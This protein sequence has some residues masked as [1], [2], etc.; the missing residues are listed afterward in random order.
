MSNTPALLMASSALKPANN[1]KKSQ[2]TSFLGLKQMLTHKRSIRSIAK[3]F[4]QMHGTEWKQKRTERRALGPVLLPRGTQGDLW[5]HLP[6]RHPLADVWD[7]QVVTET[8]SYILLGHSS[9]PGTTDTRT[10]LTGGVMKVK[11]SRDK[12]C[13]YLYTRCGST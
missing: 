8:F 6:S 5:E 13:F 7:L 1:T 9:N 11:N 3:W 2:G 10:K 4:C 12:L